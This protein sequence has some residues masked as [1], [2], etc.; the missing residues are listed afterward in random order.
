MWIS[1]HQIFWKNPRSW[2]HKIS[3]GNTAIRIQTPRLPVSSFYLVSAV[4]PD[5]KDLWIVTIHFHQWPDEVI[6]HIGKWSHLPIGT[7]YFQHMLDRRLVLYFNWRKGENKSSI[8]LAACDY[9][10]I[11]EPTFH[12]HARAKYSILWEDTS[13]LCPHWY[14]HWRSR[15][16]MK[17]WTCHKACTSCDL[18]T[19]HTSA[20]VWE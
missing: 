5:L 16:Q 14:Y 7:L 8:F 20:C 2:L 13:T 11:S 6:C 19:W 3:R 15:F 9:H 17:W 4:V 10:G 1:F 12:L 18:Q